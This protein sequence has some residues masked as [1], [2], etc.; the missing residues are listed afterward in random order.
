M[1]AFF[2]CTQGCGCVEAPGIPCALCHSR[3][4]RSGRTRTNHAAGMRLHVVSSDCV[5]RTPCSMKCSAADPGSMFAHTRVPA[6]RSSATRRTASGTRAQSTGA[7]MKDQHG[8]G[9]QLRPRY[10]A[11]LTRRRRR[12][13]PCG[14]DP[15]RTAA[16]RPCNRSFARCPDTHRLPGS[17][18][19]PRDEILA[20]SR[21]DATNDSSRDSFDGDT[22]GHAGYSPR[23]RS[24]SPAGPR[25]PS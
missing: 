25:P 10:D 16:A 9:R 5:P 23:R 14:R 24:P 1:R 17:T 20:R 22:F 18:M 12:P 7:Q 3:E 6:L 13:G 4:R 15:G 21:S 8:S 11:N 2:I 19:A